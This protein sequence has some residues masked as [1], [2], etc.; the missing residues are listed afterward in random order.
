MTIPASSTAPRPLPTYETGV[1][2]TRSG[3][4]RLYL[5]RASAAIQTPRRSATM[6][7]VGGRT[8][9]NSTGVRWEE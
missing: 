4:R 5:R 6:I 9:S 7:T 3:L 2:M 8:L 1:G